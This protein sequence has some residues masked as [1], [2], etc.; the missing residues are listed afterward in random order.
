MLGKRLQPLDQGF[1]GEVEPLVDVLQA[2]GRH[3]LDTDE[4]AADVRAPHGR[5]ELD[6]FGGLHR[7]LR[8]EHHVVRQ[9]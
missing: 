7:D 8:V 2:F 3:R 5:E 9:P 6:V 4:R 1:A